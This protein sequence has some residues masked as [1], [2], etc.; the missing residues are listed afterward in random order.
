[1][2]PQLKREAELETERGNHADIQGVDRISWEEYVPLQNIIMG[3]HLKIKL[4][5]LHTTETLCSFS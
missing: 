4:G 5:N 3:V 2:D 1:M